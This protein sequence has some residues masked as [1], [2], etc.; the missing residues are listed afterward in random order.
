MPHIPKGYLS[1]TSG[2]RPEV[3]P[4]QARRPNKTPLPYHGSGQDEEPFQVGQ[5]NKQMRK[6][7]S[8]RNFEGP[9]PEEILSTLF[10]GMEAKNGNISGPMV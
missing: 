6:S 9:T 10:P 1:S 2:I 5:R 8:I 3:V 4:R 7:I